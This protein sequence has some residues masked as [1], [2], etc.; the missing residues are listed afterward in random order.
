M[1]ANCYPDPGISISRTDKLCTKEN[2]FTAAPQILFEMEQLQFRVNEIKKH[3]KT[4][5]TD[6]KTQVNNYQ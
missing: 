6:Y 4:V 3:L 5:S 2:Y 1:L